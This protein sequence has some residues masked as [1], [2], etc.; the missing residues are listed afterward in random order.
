MLGPLS[1]KLT[2]HFLLFIV[3]TAIQGCA[4]LYKL[5][6]RPPLSPEDVARTLSQIQE[7][8]DRV[9]SFFTSGRIKVKEG[10]WE[11]EALS[12]VAARRD[13]ERVKIEITHPWGQPI[14]HLSMDGRTLSVLSF[15]KRKMYVGEVKPESLAKIFPGLFDHEVIWAVLRGYPTLKP[16]HRAVSQ[17]GGQISLLL[18]DGQ[19]IERVGMDPEQFQPVAVLYPD[20]GMKLEFAGFQENQGILYARHTKVLHPRGQLTLTTEKA[21]FNSPIPDPI[22]VLERPPGFVTE[23]LETLG[24]EKSLF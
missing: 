19:E 24:E 23:A 2:R 9:R 15:A 18:Q 6:P 3:L 8:D 12:L 10:V 16:F 4:F 1:R 5:P 7:Q 21:V 14:V 11:Q 17:E 20:M 22:F 13:P